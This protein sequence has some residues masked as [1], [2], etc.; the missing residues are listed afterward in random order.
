MVGIG[1]KSAGKSQKLAVRSP[2]QAYF[3][4]VWLRAPQ[5]LSRTN[6]ASQMGDTTAGTCVERKK[7]NVQFI[8]RYTAVLKKF[9]IYMYLVIF[10]VSIALLVTHGHEAILKF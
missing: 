7:V 10:V 3:Q 1:S 8:A 9:L 4:L 5:A 6:P 2:V